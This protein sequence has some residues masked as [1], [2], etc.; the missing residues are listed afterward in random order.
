MLAVYEGS[1][2]S[3]SFPTVG[4][5]IFK[6]SWQRDTQT[7][8]CVVRPLSPGWFA[9]LC[10]TIALLLLCT[11]ML[12]QHRKTPPAF[13]QD[14]SGITGCWSQGGQASA[15]G[16]GGRV[17]SA[18]AA[19]ARPWSTASVSRPVE[20]TRAP[21]SPNPQRGARCRDDVQTHVSQS[22]EPS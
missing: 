16:M 1:Y 14:D 18:E 21:P 22:N 5:Y 15:S 9:L 6:T 7:F 12:G 17:L 8:L 10:F 20:G 19:L 11:R 3:P 13:V 4:F 2:F